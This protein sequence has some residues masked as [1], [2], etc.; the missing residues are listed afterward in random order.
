[1]TVRSAPFITS[2]ERKIPIAIRVAW[3]A[4]DVAVVAVVCICTGNMWI[5]RTFLTCFLGVAWAVVVAEGLAACTF[6]RTV[7]GQ[8]CIFKG[9]VDHDDA[10]VQPPVERLEVNNRTPPP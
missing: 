5:R 1:V 7:L 3:A 9:A 6:T 8:A 10:L 4:F 2:L